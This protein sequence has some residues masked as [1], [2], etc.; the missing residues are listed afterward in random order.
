M[1][2]HRAPGA[3]YTRVMVAQIFIFIF[4]PKVVASGG[5]FSVWPIMTP[6]DGV[7]IPVSKFYQY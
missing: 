2:S 6:V 4:N 7:T 3:S 5:E 1:E